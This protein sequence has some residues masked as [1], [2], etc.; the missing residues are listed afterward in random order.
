MNIDEIKNSLPNGF[1]DAESLR[2]CIDYAHETADFLIDFDLSSPDS[3]MEVS[4]RQG[5][6]KLSGL[7]YC[8]IEASKSSSS[9]PEYMPGGDDKLWIASDS[10]DFG[11]LTDLPLLPDPLPEN[12]FR[13]WF[14]ITSHNSFIYVAA[15]NASFEWK[16]E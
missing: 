8:V 6:L 10:S 15:M 11:V 2:I 12:S 9:I 13:H 14:F 4:S 16:D 1:H 7:L 5:L 3:D